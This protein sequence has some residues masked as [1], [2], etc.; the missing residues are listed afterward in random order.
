MKNAFYTAMMIILMVGG[1][2][3]AGSALSH[4]ELVVHW[5]AAA[6]EISQA[7]PQVVARHPFQPPRSLALMHLAIHDALNGI[8]P[9]YKRFHCRA[10]AGDAHAAAAINQAAFTVLS[11]VYPEQKQ[12]LQ[13]I[14]AD[15]GSGGSRPS[16]R[17]GRDLGMSCARGLLASRKNDGW[18]LP[19]EH[20]F[21]AAPG[22]YR[23]T[24]EW[25]GYMLQPG[26][27]HAT[28]LLLTSQD[29]FRPSPP[30]AVH[31]EVYTSAYNEVK[32]RGGETS[33]VRNPDETGYAVW[34]MEFAEG[35][36]N[37]LARSLVKQNAPDAWQTARLFAAMNTALYD[38]YIAVW[39]SKY[40][41]DHWR[42]VT[43]IHLAEHDGNPDTDADPGWQPLRPT[44]P[45]QDYASAHATACSATF[46]VL[47]EVFGDATAFT[48][49]SRTAPEDMPTRSFESFSSAAEECADSRIQLGWHFRYAADAGL[50]LGA[51]VAEHVLDQMFEPQP[52]ESAME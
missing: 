35:S 11:E 17:K 48:M 19:G 46:T 51:E 39:D 27:R 12:T 15:L 41:F 2:P 43:A 20:R 23:S 31:S 1:S 8:E 14:L 40:E 21:T 29:Q 18:N 49:D 44:P 6:Y 47:A 24:G 3:A 26:F 45:F 7:D 42:P 34:W 38:G 5:N 22:H 28:P 16:H 13:R 37:R 50:Q 10:M 33:S 25:Q 9:R 4:S 30:P 32:R 52:P 36:V